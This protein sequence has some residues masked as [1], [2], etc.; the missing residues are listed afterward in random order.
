ME[1]LGNNIHDEL[2]RMSAHN[3]SA[4]RNL[5]I[6]EVLAHYREALENVYGPNA[7]LFLEHTNNVYIM[8]KNEVRTLIVYV[9]DSIFAAE[10]NAQREL[11]KLKL[12][13][14]FNEEIETFE[15]LIS[16]GNYKLNHPYI[17]GNDNESPDEQRKMSSQT[18]SIPLSEEEHDHVV[19]VASTIEDSTL[20]EYVQKA[21]TAD[22]EWKKGENQPGTTKNTK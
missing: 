19:S 15:I 7:Q 6:K 16:R 8:N 14:L 11:I 1:R 22:L 9:D 5:R 10:L 13:E 21:M 18:P 4:R 17:D 12:L 3:Q 2:N 20:R